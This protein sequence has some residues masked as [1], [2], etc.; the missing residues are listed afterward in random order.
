M[1]SLFDLFLYKV[2]DVKS[3]GLVTYLHD[4][5][6]LLGCIVIWYNDYW[7]SEIYVCGHLSLVGFS[8]TSKFDWILTLTL[9]LKLLYKK[10]YP[11]F[12]L[13][14]SCLPKLYL[15]FMNI[16]Y[17]LACKTGVNSALLLQIGT[18]RYN[19]VLLVPPSLE[20]WFI[21][22]MWPFLICSFNITMEDVVHLNGLNL[23]LL[24]ILLNN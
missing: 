5:G 24:C 3:L 23:L 13:F 8:V 9:L 18:F 12:V 14:I 1:E 17:D 11:W 7:H 22:E 20:S 2:A 10:L 16:P 19:V 15:I 4:N 21:V 6:N